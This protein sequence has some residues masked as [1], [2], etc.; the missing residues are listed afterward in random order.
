MASNKLFGVDARNLIVVLAIIGAV[1][2]L[3][4]NVNSPFAVTSG[5]QVTSID[6]PN[7]ITGNENLRDLNWRVTTILG[8]N[9]QVQFSIN[10]DQFAAESGTRSERTF[11]ASAEAIQETLRYTINQRRDAALF[12]FT[13]NPVTTEPCTGNWLRQI[14]RTRAFRSSQYICI[15]D[16]YQGVVGSVSPPSTQFS[17]ELTISNGQSTIRERIGNAES[18]G[19]VSFRQNGEVIGVARW[20]GNLVTGAEEPDIPQGAVLFSGSSEEWILVE[21]SDISN[22]L[23]AQTIFINQL[24]DELLRADQDSDGIT[25]SYS[26]QEFN[27]LQERLSLNAAQLERAYNQNLQPD[28]VIGGQFS[29]INGGST[30]GAYLNYEAVN[31]LQNPQVVWDLRAD[32][33]GIEILSSEPV[34]TNLQAEEFAR[35]EQGVILATIENQGNEQGVA[36]VSLSPSCNDFSQTSTNPRTTLNAGASD[37]VALYVDTPIK[38]T[39]FNELCQVCVRD[40]ADPSREDCSEVQLS[41]SATRVCTPN[42]VS[43]SANENAIYQ[44]DSEGLNKNLL[45]TCGN[46]LEPAYTGDGQYEGYECADTRTI[47]DKVTDI[48]D[49]LTGGTDDGTDEVVDEGRNEFAGGVAI[50][51]AIL[52]LVGSLLVIGATT[53]WKKSKAL[54]TARYIL[55]ILVFVGVFIL[56]GLIAQAVVG[57]FTLSIF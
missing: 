13:I 9:E 2:L 26:E 51:A 48:G 42:Q 12:T 40:V 49:G 56:V 3:F 15:Y 30:S 4:T 21:E 54:N 14:E 8:G 36:E 43:I 55:A 39:D 37:T 34:I 19:S 35:D 22:A 33:I 50:F 1:F 44:C 53:A 46:G 5:V 23:N 11:T 25:E 47:Q 20:T 32:W 41:F 45:E 28:Q 6:E 24:E 57:L 7:Y 52:G 38:N 31:R 10:P 29:L 16:N 18:P 27:D 17:A